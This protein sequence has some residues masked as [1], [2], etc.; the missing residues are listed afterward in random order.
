[1]EKFVTVIG[2]STSNTSIVA[3]VVIKGGHRSLT[4]T[5]HPNMLKQ[6]N[7]KSEGLL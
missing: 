4:T 6:S 1:M 2:R 3:S 5:F 7:K